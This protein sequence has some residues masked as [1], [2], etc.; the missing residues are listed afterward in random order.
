MSAEI[1]QKQQTADKNGERNPEV[2]VGGDRA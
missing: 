1:V 2:D